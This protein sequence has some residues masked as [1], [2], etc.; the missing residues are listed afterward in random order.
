MIYE[1]TVE[2]S[3][4]AAH[5]LSGY[6]GKC[7][8]LHGHEWTIYVTVQ[9]KKL[10]TDK[11]SKGMVVDF[12][13]LK[14]VVKEKITEVFDHSFIYEIGTIPIELKNNMIE[15]MNWKLNEVDFRP[16]AENFAEYIYN[17]ISAEGYNV[18]E[19]IVYETR[20]NKAVYRRK[21]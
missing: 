3:F 6:N 8:N 16:T 11:Q 2:D 7:H 14:K 1:V 17:I 13:E 12:G 20:K 19:V 5:F 10:S 18:S 9:S 21:D 4:D 15:L